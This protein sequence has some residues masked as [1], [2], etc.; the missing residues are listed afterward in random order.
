MSVLYYERLLTSRDQE[1]VKQEADEKMAKL[2]PS[3]FVRD[4]LSNEMG[5]DSTLLVL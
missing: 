4:Q 3:Y 5:P 2:E 1:L